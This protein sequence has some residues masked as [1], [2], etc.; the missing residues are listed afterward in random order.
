MIENSF[1]R[2]AVHKMSATIDLPVLREQIVQHT[3]DSLN[4]DHNFKVA[5]VWLKDQ[6]LYG[7]DH[8]V[9]ELEVEW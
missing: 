6:E 3:L 5:R 2:C 8:V 4:G 9:V 1:P 7:D